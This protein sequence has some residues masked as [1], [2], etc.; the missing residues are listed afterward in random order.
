MMSS[1]H[2]QSRIESVAK[3]DVDRVAREYITPERM[4]ILVVG[5]RAAIERPLES[6]P[7]VKSIQRLDTEGNSLPAPAAAKPA[8]AA[9]ARS[10]SRYR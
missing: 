5:D 4:A 1:T 3:A 9:R 8:A 10:A 2:Y 6:L 7:F